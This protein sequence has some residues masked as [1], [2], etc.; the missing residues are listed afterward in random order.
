MEGKAAPSTVFK[1]PASVLFPESSA[2]CCRETIAFT[3]WLQA[4]PHPNQQQQLPPLLL[5]SLG[6]RDAKAS[7]ATSPSCPAPHGSCPFGL[8]HCHHLTIYPVCASPLVPFI[9]VRAS[10]EK[11]TSILPLN[12][13]AECPTSS[14]AITALGVMRLLTSPVTHALQGCGWFH[15]SA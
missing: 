12:D 4:E 1:L 2:F 9:P 14:V 13:S 11:T 10:S 5:N 7:F 8:H 3:A 15:I 6:G